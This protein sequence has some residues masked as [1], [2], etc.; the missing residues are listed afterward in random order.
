MFKIITTI[1]HPA[2]RRFHGAEAARQQ[3]EAEVLRQAALADKKKRDAATDSLRI[4]EAHVKSYDLI[5]IGTHHG[6]P[7]ALSDLG[8]EV[9]QRL[10]LAVA[11]EREPLIKL[12]DK[13]SDEDIED[14]TSRLDPTALRFLLEHEDPE[15]QR[16][17]AKKILNARADLVENVPQDQYATIVAEMVV[18]SR[19]KLRRHRAVLA[20]QVR[21]ILL[22]SADPRWTEQRNGVLRPL[23]AA[24]WK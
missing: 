6:L 14:I 21:A 10:D 23:T 22:R 17:A 13:M 11:V 1:L 12:A 4:Y 9:G 19:L 16:S 18:R 2:R 8:K 15:R 3:E 7:V 5:G 20:V 24:P